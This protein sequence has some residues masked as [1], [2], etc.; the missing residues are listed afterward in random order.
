VT[1]P[2]LSVLAALATTLL[3]AASGPARADWP[4]GPAAVSVRDTMTFHPA[5]PSADTLSY[6]PAIQFFD[7]TGHEPLVVSPPVKLE[8]QP[9]TELLRA[10]MG[11][12]L[13]DHP[14]AWDRDHHRHSEDFDMVV[15][16]NRVD[17]LRWGAHYQAQRPQTMY[18]RLGARLEYATG[19]D[20]T[21]YGVQ[22][23][24]P[25]LPTARFV[26]GVSMVRRTDHPELQQVE[27]L[28]N[29]LAMLLART[30]YRDYFE[31]EGAGIYLS[32]RRPMTAGSPMPRPF[33]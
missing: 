18:P 24:Q 16:Y 23:E 3:V 27:D 6:T 28:E 20:R 22:V 32:W 1:S 2:R 31:R 26:F 13:L 7:S 12:H 29:S 11:D 14:E 30:D 17:I 21:L 8:Y 4:A 9:D 10:P 19:R 25:L 33:R 15:D 5:G